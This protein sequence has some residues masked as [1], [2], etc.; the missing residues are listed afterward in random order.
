[1]MELQTDRLNLAPLTLEDVTL[2]HAM[3]TDAF[4]R[5]YLWDDEVIDPEESESMLERNEELFNESNYGL[6]KIVLKESGDVIGYAGLWFFFNEPL[7]QLVYALKE[8]FT[9]QG[10]AT[11]ASR[12]VMAY[13]FNTLKFPFLLAAM[14]KPNSASHK[15]AQRLRMRHVETSRQ[16]ERLT[17]FYRIDKAKFE[18]VQKEEQDKKE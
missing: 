12:E 15:V 17:V 11:E 13:A 16:N 6:W 1:M 2:F 10:Y 4:V 3:N 7:P 14:D 9:G 18:E 8:E 5:K